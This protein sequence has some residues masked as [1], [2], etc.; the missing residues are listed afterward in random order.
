ME[1]ANLIVV[2]IGIKGAN[3]IVVKGWKCQPDCRQGAIIIVVVQLCSS[4]QRPG[5]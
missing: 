2:G 5:L 1:G 4:G 3:I